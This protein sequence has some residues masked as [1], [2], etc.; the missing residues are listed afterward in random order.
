MIEKRNNVIGHNI[1]DKEGLRYVFF[2]MK[3]LTQA[4]YDGFQKDGF[5]VIDDFLSGQEVQSAI[6]GI[7]R[8]KTAAAAAPASADSGFHLEKAGDNSFDANAAVKEP[9]MFRKIQGAVR[10]PELK[11][12]FTSSKMVECMNDLMTS[13]D[14]YYHSS[15]VMFKPANGGAAKPWHQDAAYW[16]QFEPRQITIWIALND[17]TE[18]NGCIWVVPASHKLGLIPHVKEEPQ[19]EESESLVDWSKKIAV[20]VKAGGLLIFHS[21][22]LHMSHKNLSDKSRWAIICDYDSLP[23]PAVDSSAAPFVDDKGIWKLSAA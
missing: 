14:V 11:D 1:V 23:N 15:K 2:I 19:V 22:V 13:D 4:Q 21:L 3:Y 6:S 5:L 20:P 16:R 10:V 9:G 12:I 7:E 18:E 8:E 17:S